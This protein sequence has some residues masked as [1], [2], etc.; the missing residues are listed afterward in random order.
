[1]KARKLFATLLM[2]VMVFASVGATSVDASRIP[3]YTGF[4]GTYT[5]SF[6]DIFSLEMTS[7]FY[8]FPNEIVATSANYKITKSNSYY[9]INVETTLGK[10]QSSASTLYRINYKKYNES[11][12]KFKIVGI[13]GTEDGKTRFIQCV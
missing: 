4:G 8:V 6:G 9:D 12:Y 13:V 7:G 3:S 5:Y 2:M 10:G 1:M 11:T